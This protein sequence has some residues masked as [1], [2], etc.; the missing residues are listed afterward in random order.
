MFQTPATVTT[1]ENAG[2]KVWNVDYC[3][4]L[5]HVAASRV[6]WTH[7][8]GVTRPNGRGAI[9][10]VWARLDIDGNV[11]ATSRATRIPF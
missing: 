8:L 1:T 11:T 10:T 3:K 2:R 4:A 9:Y 6:R 5:N 7:Y